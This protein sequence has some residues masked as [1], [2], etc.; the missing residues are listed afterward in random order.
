MAS[1]VEANLGNIEKAKIM[2]LDIRG[3]DISQEKAVMAN[4]GFQKM[5]L[6]GTKLGDSGMKKIVAGQLAGDPIASLTFNKTG[7]ITG[8][9]WKEYIVPFNPSTLSIR[10]R[11]QGFMPILAYGQNGATA[12]PGKQ[13]VRVTI[14]V[15]LIFDKV[16]P[17]DAFM[18]DKASLS[19]TK[20]GT[21]IAKLAIASNGGRED[22]SVQK[23]VEGFIAALR[24]PYTRLVEF[25]WGEMEY[26]GVLNNVSAQYVMFNLQGQPVRAHVNLSIL[27]MDDTQDPDTLGPWQDA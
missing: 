20:L 11:G 5:S 2:I 26:C 6:G 21:N 1:V 7:R 18:E 13:S 14:T 8:A 17:A 23:Q 16:D 3:R 9:S 15:Q 22:L 27:H 12:E 25:L 4:G 10:G 24:S 19:P